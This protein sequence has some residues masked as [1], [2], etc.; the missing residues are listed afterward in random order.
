MENGTVLQVLT[1][2]VQIIIKFLG[3]P[4]VQWQLLAIGLVLVLAWGLSKLFIAWLNRRFPQQPASP[5]QN[6]TPIGEVEEI[7][8]AEEEEEEV[9]PTTSTNWR[10]RGVDLLLNFVRQ[11]AYPVVALGLAYPTLALFTLQNWPGGLIQEFNLILW[12]FMGYRVIVGLLNATIK[13]E[14]VQYYR[15]RLVLPLFTVTVLLLV[16]GM[17]T[18]LTILS[19]APLSTAEE[20]NPLTLGRVVIVVV[21]FYFWF[22]LTHVLYD[23]LQAITTRRDQGSSGTMQASLII[24]RYLLII[25]GAIVVLQLLQLDTT[26]VAAITGGLSIGLGFALQDVI[27]NFL[28][29][30]ILLFEG[31]IRPGDWVEVEG[32]E[33]EV[34]SLRIRATIIRRLD[35]VRIIVPNQEWL[36]SR[37]TTYTHGGRRSLVKV[38]VGVSYRS[39]LQQIRDLLIETA[40]RHPDVL[41]DPEPAAILIN[42]GASSLDIL[43]AAWV[44]D[45]SIR[46]RVANELRLM[47]WDTF[48]EHGIEIPYPQQDVHLHPDLLQQESALQAN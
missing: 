48:E 34:E 6:E 46:R 26:T 40:R 7:I 31:T 11:L 43:V 36:N 44:G 33:G 42:F 38:S 12:L 29:G 19:N 9:D 30:I 21:G 27:K 23:G 39:N 3:R 47:I 45:A 20:E 16:L 4:A 22:I 37:V 25:A 8:E 13:P 24:G 5:P 41:Y 14:T 15:T 1:D 18:Q 28:G 32:V 17:L 2:L 10:E 35:D